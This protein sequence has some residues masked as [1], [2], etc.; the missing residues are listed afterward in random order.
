MKRERSSAGLLGSYRRRPVCTATRCRQA[1]TDRQC[2]ATSVMASGKGRHR[3]SPTDA[4][5][6][7]RWPALA[8]YQEV[9]EDSQMT[10]P[11][12]RTRALVY[13]LRFLQDLQDPAATPG[14]PRSVRERARALERHYPTLAAM[15]L[16]HLALP[17]LYGPVAPFFSEPTEDTPQRPASSHGV[18]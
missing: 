16:A 11:Y 13:T 7:A 10:I 9:P 2:Y 12:E 18:E 15:D 4:R 5:R 14:V 17:V 3:M 8:Q 1:R 6:G